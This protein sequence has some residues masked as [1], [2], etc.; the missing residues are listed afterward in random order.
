MTIETICLITISVLCLV[1]CL[2]CAL[3]AYAWSKAD[4]EANEWCEKWYDKD[5]ELRKAK[6]RIDKR[7]QEALHLRL[8]VAAARD[9]AN[10]LLAS[11]SPTGL[12]STGLETR[13]TENCQLK[14]ENSDPTQAGSLGYDQ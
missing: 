4:E 11:L 2:A 7:R 1:L 8:Q 6:E 5:V 12:D 14:T 3:L 9:Y 13:P 10:E